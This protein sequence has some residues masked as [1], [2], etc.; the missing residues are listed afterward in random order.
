[1]MVFHIKSKQTELK[2]EVVMRQKVEHIQTE[3]I[4]WRKVKFLHLVIASTT[5]HEV[6]ESVIQILCQI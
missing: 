6:Q 1:M 2:L 4:L 3:L 5:V